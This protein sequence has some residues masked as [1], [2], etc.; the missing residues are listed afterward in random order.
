[1]VGDGSFLFS[2]PQP[3]WSISRY[4]APITVM[5]LNNRSYN[6]ER[7]R[8]WS[9]SGGAQLRRGMDMTCYNGSPECRLRQDRRGFGVEGETI[10]DP[11][12]DP[13]SLGSI[14]ARQYRRAPLLPRGGYRARRRRRGVGV[15]SAILGRRPPDEKGLIMARRFFLAALAVLLFAVHPAFAQQAG[16]GDPFLPP[17]DGHDLVQQVCTSLPSARTFAQIRQAIGVA[18][19]SLQ[20]DDGRHQVGPDDIGPI[21]KYLT[22]STARACRSSDRRRRK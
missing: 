12:Q 10:T 14:E 13:R 18:P 4:K 1:M 15:V 8:I 21:V 20:D 17:G 16:G 11:S 9:F 19:P 2:G 6:N 5:V 3:L 7:N 22:A